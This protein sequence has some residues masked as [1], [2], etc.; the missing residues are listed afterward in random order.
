[1][2]PVEVSGRRL[3]GMIFNQLAAFSVRLWSDAWY[4][5]HCDGISSQIADRLRHVG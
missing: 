3:D 4:W 1:V 5:K 2:L